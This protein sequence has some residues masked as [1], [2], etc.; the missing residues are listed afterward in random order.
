[1]NRDPREVLGVHKRATLAKCK[2]AYH[3][4]V[5][6][7]HPDRNS[8][9]PAAAKRFKEVQDAWDRLNGK[10]SDAALLDNK[11]V[12]NLCQLFIQVTGELL[13]KDVDPSGSDVKAMM[14]DKLTVHR[15]DIVRRVRVVTA[16]RDQVAKMAGRWSGKGKTETPLE[17]VICAKLTEAGVVLAAIEQERQLVEE[18]L[19]MLGGW[20]Y[21]V[22]APT[23]RSY[24]GV[25]TW[26]RPGDL[27]EAIQVYTTA[28]GS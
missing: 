11:V 25:A 24:G 9:D 18:S 10:G 27:M 8:D 21:R 20:A 14:R 16:Q 17:Q 5:M 23:R 15:D 2:R 1:M 26:Q 3:K 4:L 12:G 19:K 28:T 13:S 22:E 6:E 7:L